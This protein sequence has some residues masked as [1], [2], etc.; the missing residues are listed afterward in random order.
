VEFR[1]LDVKEKYSI[2]DYVNNR[3]LGVLKGDDPY[4]NIS[5]NDCLL[6]EL[7]PIK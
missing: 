1:G 4:L 3:D 7:K 6:V 2:V 5:F